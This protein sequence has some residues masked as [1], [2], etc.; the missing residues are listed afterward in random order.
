MTL[1]GNKE[2]KNR[3]ISFYAKNYETCV[4]K[5]GALAPNGLKDPTNLIMIYIIYI[6]HVIL[7]LF[8]DLFDYFHRDVYLQKTF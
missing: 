1:K 2:N 3:L 8:F 5:M 7:Y 6:N 4:F